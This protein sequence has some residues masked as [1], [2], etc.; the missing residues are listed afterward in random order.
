[1]FAEI[2]ADIYLLVDGDDTYDASRSPE[3]VAALLADDLDMVTAV[4]DDEGEIGAYRAVTSSGMRYSIGCS[5]S[6]SASD[7]A[8]R[9]PVT[10]RC[11]DVS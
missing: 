4:R 8:M 7:P 1:M 6:F 9:S 10:A 3:L 2:D 11:R 5:A